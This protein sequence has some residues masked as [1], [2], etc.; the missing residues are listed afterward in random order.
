M[1]E[2]HTY[3]LTLILDPNLNE[4]QLQTERDAV[5]TLLAR[6]EGELEKVDEWGLKRLAYPIRKLNEGYYLVYTLRLPRSAP[7]ALES[8]L[9]LRDNVMRALITRDRPEWRTRKAPQPTGEATP[10]TP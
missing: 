9:R 1:A 5:S 2:T 3:T 4:A 8:S 10:A 6:V 7:K